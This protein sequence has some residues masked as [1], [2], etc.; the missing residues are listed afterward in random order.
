MHCSWILKK[1][2]RVGEGAV[3]FRLG[4]PSWRVGFY[5]IGTV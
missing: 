5:P 1:E 2:V 4:T 3:S